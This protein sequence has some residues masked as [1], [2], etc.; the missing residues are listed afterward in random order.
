MIRQD[1]ITERTL[2]AFDRLAVFALG[3]SAIER[4]RDELELT[5]NHNVGM[6]IDGTGTV[7]LWKGP[8]K[9][10]PAVT[11]DVVAMFVEPDGASC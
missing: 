4:M 1:K 7:T 10:P 8:A 6:W 9:Q 2:V 5:T 3:M 11:D